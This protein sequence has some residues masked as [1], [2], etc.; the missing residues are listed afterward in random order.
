M[1]EHLQSRLDVVFGA[2]ADPTRPQILRQL[3][4]GDLTV[5]DIAEPFQSSLAAV[6]KP[7]KLRDKAQQ[8]K[9]RVERRQYHVQLNAC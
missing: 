1:F 6:S 7:L 8:I 2:L 5:R 3:A 9:R 4:G